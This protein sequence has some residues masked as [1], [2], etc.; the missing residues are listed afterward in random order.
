MIYAAT[1]SEYKRVMRWW[2]ILEE[3]G[4]N[5]KHIDGVDN[6]LADTLIRLPYTTVYKYKARMGKSQCR[7]KELFAIGRK[8]NNEDLPL[9]N[10][11]NVKR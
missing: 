10:I 1:L 2:L 8:E 6:I 9:I 7:A 3:F 11:L 5:I 4:P